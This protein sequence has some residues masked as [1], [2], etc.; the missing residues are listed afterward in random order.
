MSRKLLFLLILAGFA[1][2]LYLLLGRDFDTELFLDGFSRIRPIWLIAATVMTFI[3]YGIRA[4]RWQILLISLKLIR[5]GPLASTTLIGFGAIYLLGR[6]GEVVRPVWLARRERI[7][8]AGSFATIVVERVFDMLML[9]V[10]LAASLGLV[11]LPVGTEGAVE[12][13]ESAS[14]L[15][16]AIATTALAGFAIF[17]RNVD[18]I[19]QRLPFERLA[20]A[21]RTFSEGLAITGSW[22]SLTLTSVYSLLLWLGIALQF[23][24]M[25]VGL[26][27]EFGFGTTTLILVVSAIGS[28][29]Q[30]PGIGG[31]FQAAFVFCLTTFF[32][33]PLETAVATSLMA[34]LF[35]IVPTIGVAAIYMTWKGLTRQELT[36]DTGLNV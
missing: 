5:L 27:F 26:G 8:A 34:W 1:G 2:L 14:W 23:W 9:I 19:V 30:V 24:L 25:M 15:L 33:V 18:A 32:L 28:I 21:L 17:R 7:S 20:K 36:A 4:M 29:V 22:R 16:T 6:A 11:R 31:G 13:L 12:D 10:L 35:T 3:S